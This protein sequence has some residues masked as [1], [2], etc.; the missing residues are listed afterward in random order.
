MRRRRLDDA[1]AAGEAGRFVPSAVSEEQI[2]LANAVQGLPPLHRAAVQLFYGEGMSV[3][4]I[5]MVLNIPAGTVK[6]R[7]H[8]AREALKLQLGA[9]A[10]L[11]HDPK[12][13]RGKIS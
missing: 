2:D 11:G 6:S 10:P 8:H 12:S 4:E 1:A 3:E 13:R 9:A 7:L 5:A